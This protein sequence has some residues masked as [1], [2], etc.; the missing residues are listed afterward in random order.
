MYG[1]GVHGCILAVE[2][3]INQSLQRYNWTE[4]H[5]LKTI[6]IIFVFSVVSWAWLLFKLPNF[7]HVILYTKA[8]FN[9]IS[10]QHNKLVIMFVFLYSI[11]VIIYHSMYLFRSKISKLSK[12]ESIFYG[13]MIFLILMNS[14]ENN[15]FIYFQF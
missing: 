5:L 10:S 3:C 13:I 6:K 7:D 1:G 4:N 2:R 12:Y 8:I 9:N 11:P 15:A 14:G